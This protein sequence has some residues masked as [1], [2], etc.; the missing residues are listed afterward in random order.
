VNG[1]FN[2]DNKIDLA[3]GAYGYTSNIGRAYI[4]Y[5]DGT[6]PTTA[7]TADVIITGQ[8]TGNY[9][10]EVMVS[11]DFNADGK[12]DLAVAMDS[13][14]SGAGQICIFYNDG[15]IPTTAATADV[16]ITGGTNNTFGTS[17][18]GGDFNNDGKT[19]LVAGAYFIGKAYIFYNDGS[20]PT[21]SSAADIIIDGYSPDFNYF[22]SVMASGDF[23]ADGKIDLAV[24]TD[25]NSRRV[26]IFYND[27]SIPSL[28]SGADIKISNQASGF[29]YA[30]I[31][32][33]FNADGKTDLGVGGYDTDEDLNFSI[34]T[35]DAP[36]T[37]PDYIQMN[38]SV[39][40][41]GSVLLQQ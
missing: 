29:G 3:V 36:G 24:G 6:I 5:N 18:A 33:D 4:F 39:Q 11:G 26:F 21:A 15:S 17:L 20:Y 12:T 37:K 7:V 16:R 28:V 23:N 32:G 13:Y 22:G 9:F 25:T 14:G 8:S 2:A 31:S 19:D 35:V 10:S 41:N 34:Y 1:D 30:L 40:L 38:G 27:G